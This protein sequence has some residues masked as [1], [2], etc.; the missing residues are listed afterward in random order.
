MRATDTAYTEWRVVYLKGSALENFQ[1]K[2]TLIKGVDGL[3]IA[4]VMSTLWTLP[5]LHSLTQRKNYR[6]LLGLKL[7][8]AKHDKHY[9]SRS[10]QTSPATAGPC[11]RLNFGPRVPICKDSF[12]RRTVTNLTVTATSQIITNGAS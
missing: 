2:S 9:P 1:W 5:D 11:I 3:D 8:F 12:R 4:E 10:R 6:T 7:L